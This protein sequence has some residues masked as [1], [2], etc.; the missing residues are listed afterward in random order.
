M[1]TNAESSSESASPPTDAKSG[2]SDDEELIAWLRDRDAFC[3]LCQYNVRG[4]ASPRCPECGQKLRL[5]VALVD[6]YLK[7]WIALMVAVCAGA[8]IGMLFL[9]ALAREGWPRGGDEYA[10]DAAILLQILMIPTAAVV[11]FSRRRFQRL[12]RQAQWLIAAIGIVLV[13]LSYVLFL[14]EMS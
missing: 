7:A 12:S 8:G 1:S 3:P 2:R 11:L 10:A 14:A 6:P 13:S 4:L 5:T 9:Y